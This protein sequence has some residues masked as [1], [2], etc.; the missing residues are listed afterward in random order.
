MVAS[1]LIPSARHNQST[2]EGRLPDHLGPAEVIEKI[3]VGD[4]ARGRPR[5]LVCRPAFDRGSHGHRETCLLEFIY[6]L[7]LGDFCKEMSTNSNGKP[8][9]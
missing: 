7:S 3:D 8:A 5:R 9:A 2:A 4:T 1:W 6:L